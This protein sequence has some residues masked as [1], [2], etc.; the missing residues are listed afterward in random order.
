MH[1]DSQYL[2]DGVC[3]KKNKGANINKPL[4]VIQSFSEKWSFRASCFSE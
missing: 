1:L 4:L 2:G 3:K